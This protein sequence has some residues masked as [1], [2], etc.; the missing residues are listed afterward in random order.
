[1]KQTTVGIQLP[2][3]I[4]DTLALRAEDMGLSN[5]GY[6]GAILKRFLEKGDI[7]ILTDGGGDR[8]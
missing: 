7:L 4:A 3:D 1:M 5:S 2:P 6:I 8:R